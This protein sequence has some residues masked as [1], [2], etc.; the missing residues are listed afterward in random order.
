MSG[1]SEKFRVGSIVTKTIRVD[2]QIVNFTT[3]LIGVVEWEETVSGVP[4]RGVRWV[5]HFNLTAMYNV[6]ELRPASL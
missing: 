5:T 6:S 3:P 2:N 1:D 4:M